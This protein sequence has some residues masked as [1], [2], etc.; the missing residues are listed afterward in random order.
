M[1]RLEKI[2]KKANDTMNAWYGIGDGVEDVKYLL[3]LIEQS[4]TDQAPSGEPEKRDTLEGRC[5]CGNRNDTNSF[6]DFR[7]EPPKRLC[8]DCQ[9]E[10]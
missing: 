6:I 10:V 1:D 8:W 3:S 5:K 7:Q 9:K 2:R 4:P